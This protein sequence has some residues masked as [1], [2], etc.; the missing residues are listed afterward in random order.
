MRDTFAKVL[1]ELAENNKDIMLLTADLGF[2]VLD[3]FAKKLPKQ[4]INVGVAEQNMSGIAT[5]LALNGKIVFTYSIAN[6]PTLRCLEQIR[7][8]VCYHDVSVKIVAIG[9]G[10]SYGALGMS[11]HATE[12]LAILRTFP[13][14][15]ISPCDLFEVE[16]AT[17]SMVQES[18]PCYLRID[19]SALSFS[20]AQ[21]DFK[22]GKARVLRD[23]KDLTVIGTG[24]ILEE[25]FI[26]ADKLALEKVSCRI[27]SM[28]TIKPIDHEAIAKSV[29]ETGGIIT[30][31]EHTLYGGLGS[32]VAE[33]CMEHGIQPKFFH[34]IGMRSGFSSI[35]GSQNY[36]RKMYKM[37]ADEIYNV[38]IRL[39]A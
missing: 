6:F 33:V 5:G 11:H 7:N 29:L 28:H 27:I 21:R 15:V 30:L 8:D 17:K 36:L 37:D 12:D 38:A 16:Q 25:A 3:N 20:H 24:G 9:G 19:K 26:A 1:T 23:G 10:F 35:V 2:G 13:M 18:G 22:P 4:F 39:T 34:R 31:E 32:A 14:T